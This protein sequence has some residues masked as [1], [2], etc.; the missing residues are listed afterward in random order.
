ME[1]R[2]SAL[3]SCLTDKQKA[4]LHWTYWGR[5][6]EGSYTF[7]PGFALFDLHLIMD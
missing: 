2:E 3:Q 6:Q 1:L 5:G 4:N 7:S